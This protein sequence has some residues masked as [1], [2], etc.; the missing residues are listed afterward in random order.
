MRRFLLRKAAYEPHYQLVL[1]KTQTRANTPF[2]P[3]NIMLQLYPIRNQMGFARS[4]AQPMR[5]CQL[6]LGYCNECISPVSQYSFH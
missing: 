2:C 1:F 5:F 4:I 3:F 6:I